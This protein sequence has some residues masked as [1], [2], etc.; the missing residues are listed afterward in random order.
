MFLVVFQDLVL[1]LLETRGILQDFS[2]IAQ[3]PKHNHHFLNPKLV[4]LLIFA[5][6]INLFVSLAHVNPMVENKH[7]NEDLELLMSPASYYLHQ[8]RP[9]LNYD[10]TDEQDKR[11]IKD[12]KERKYN[13]L[14]TTYQALNPSY[15]A[16]ISA[17]NPY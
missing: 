17:L 14:L 8:I 3:L 4:R 15:F 5:P 1:A 11:E 12:S 6:K 10:F 16:H 7:L 9:V 13:H 2:M